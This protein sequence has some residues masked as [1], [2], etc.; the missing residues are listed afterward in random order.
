MLAPT[1]RRRCNWHASSECNTSTIYLGMNRGDRRKA[2]FN[3]DQD[4]LLFLDTLA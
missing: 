3:D 4:R 2:I 1:S